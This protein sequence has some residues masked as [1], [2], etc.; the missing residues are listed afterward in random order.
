MQG[1]LVDSVEHHVEASTDY[2]KQGHLELK[3][4][5]MYQ[6][7]ARKVFSFSIPLRPSHYTSTLI[8]TTTI[9]IKRKLYLP[10][11]PPKFH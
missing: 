1:E 3:Q 5:E 10:H 4:A 6:S 9:Q 11:S 8:L 2:I 7:K